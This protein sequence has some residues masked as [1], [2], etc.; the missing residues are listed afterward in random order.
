MVSSFCPKAIRVNKK[1]LEREFK[2]E[3]GAKEKEMQKDERQLGVWMVNDTG[4][5]NCHP[6]IVQA[7]C[8]PQSKLERLSA[9]N[10]AYQAG[11]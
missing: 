9:S 2:H 11:R 4:I 5:A 3:R 1:E 6:I 8:H 7:G 10:Q